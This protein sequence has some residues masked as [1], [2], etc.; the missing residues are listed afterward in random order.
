VGLTFETEPAGSVSVLRCYGR[1]T[2]GK[3]SGAFSR[4][5]AE[6]LPH[7][8]RLTVDLSQVET[9][10]RDG[11]GEVVVALMWAQASG[12]E[13]KLAAPSLRVYQL[14]ELTNLLEVFETHATL[15][16]AVLSFR[17]GT[18]KTRAAACSAA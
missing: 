14:L 6:L 1:V 9:I 2:N 5:V 13:V 16:E 7:T 18:E 8:H 11:L 10:D 3:E 15:E 17:Q 12:C 4:K